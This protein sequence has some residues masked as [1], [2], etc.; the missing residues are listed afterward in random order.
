MIKITY[1]SFLMS[2]SKLLISTSS[3]G[4]TVITFP[5]VIPSELSRILAL[6]RER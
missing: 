6:Y 1:L 2:N 5:P 4:S 3:K